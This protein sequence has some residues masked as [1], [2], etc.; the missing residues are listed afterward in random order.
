MRSKRR[1]R[2]HSIA[3]RPHSLWALGWWLTAFIALAGALTWMS[4]WL[5]PTTGP[6]VTVYRH[7][8]C[9]CCSRWVEHLRQSGFRV[10]MNEN[11]PLVDVRA[12][13]GVPVSLASCHTATVGPYT[14]E[15]HVPADDLRRLL[16]E[17]PPIRGLAVP[18]MPVGSPGMEGGQPEPYHV[19]T[20]GSPSG[21]T[22]FAS[23]GSGASTRPES[24]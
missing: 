18:D 12:R 4:S 16:R 15:G 14:I 8:D 2:S 13:L 7:P 19:I 10:Q 17:R 6:V 22:I 3:Q 11:E 1:P 23:H 24:P 21:E 5:R 20:F 9:Q